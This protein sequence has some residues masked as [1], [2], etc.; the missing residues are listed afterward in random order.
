MHLETLCRPFTY[1]TKLPLESH[2]LSLEWRRFCNYGQ[3]LSFS[4]LGNY[5]GLC[6]T[7]TFC[8]FHDTFASLNG[9]VSDDRMWFLFQTPSPWS[10]DIRL[11]I[12]A[13]PDTPYSA[14]FGDFPRRE[15]VVNPDMTGLLVVNMPPDVRFLRPVKMEFSLPVLFTEAAPT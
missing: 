3:R 10:Q 11:G 13:M 8:R 14:A 4:S 7:G 5:L 1:H 2:P 6:E 12:Y 15:F 9:R